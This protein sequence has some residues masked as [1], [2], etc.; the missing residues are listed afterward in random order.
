[1]DRLPFH[2]KEL[3]YIGDRE[4]LARSFFLKEA[5][6]RDMHQLPQ[7]APLPFLGEAEALGSEWFAVEAPSHQACRGPHIVFKWIRIALRIVGNGS[8]MLSEQGFTQVFSRWRCW[9]L[10]TGRQAVVDQF[11]HTGVHARKRVVNDLLMFE[12]HGSSVLCLIICL[13]YGQVN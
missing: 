12:Y 1:M 3:T 4:Q 11:M 8:K 2:S 7:F 9:S 13:V 5:E 10:P 6:H